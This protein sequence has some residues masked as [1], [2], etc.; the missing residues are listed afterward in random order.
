MEF[1]T[2]LLVLLLVCTALTQADLVCDRC[3]CFGTTVN[4]SFHTLDLHPN[5][6]EWP[7]DMEVTDLLMDN[8]VLVHVTQYPAMAVRYLSLSHNR[9]VRIDNEAFLE[10]KNLT[11][12]DLSHNYIT[13]S[14]L[15]AAMFKVKL[16]SIDEFVC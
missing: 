10:L 16:T 15:N 14:N 1:W 13:A 7:R 9:I 8:N 5:A 11:E 4:C 2:G 12:L 6:S 3:T